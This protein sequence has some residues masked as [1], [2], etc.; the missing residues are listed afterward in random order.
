MGDVVEGR[1]R[2]VNAALCLICS[3]VVVSR[4]RHDFVTCACGTLSVDG[5]ADAEA[6]AHRKKQR[7]ARSRR[8]FGRK[9]SRK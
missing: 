4:H 9:G 1:D 7:K 8:R 3:Q 5:G 2:A 6:R